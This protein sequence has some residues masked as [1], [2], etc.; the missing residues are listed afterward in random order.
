M[1]TDTAETTLQAATA[2]GRAGQGQA[3]V[4]DEALP[5]DY[6]AVFNYWAECVMA[7]R[8]G[9]S[10]L[11]KPPNA[12]VAGFFADSTNPPAPGAYP[13]ESGE[14]GYG[15]PTGRPAIKPMPLYI[16]YSYARVA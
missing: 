1:S 13:A 3:N 7:K 2:N 14:P 15:M 12:F 4:R 9:S 16:E 6:L 10:Y 8:A 5:M 11:P